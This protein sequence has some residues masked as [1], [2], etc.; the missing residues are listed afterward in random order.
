MKTPFHP[1]DDESRAALLEQA[2]AWLARRDRGLTAA[3]QDAFLHWLHEDPRHREALA[4]LQKAWLTLDGLVEWQPAYSAQPNPDLLAPPRR[5]RRLFW[6]STVLAAGL[7]AAATVALLLRTA[8]PSAAPAPVPAESVA[9]VRIIPGPEREV[10][11]DGSVATL[12]DG[13]R[14]VA[15]FTPSERRVR[16]ISGELYVAVAKNPDRPFV[17]EADGIAVRAIGTAFNVRR[18]SGVLEVLVTEGRVQ[19]ETPAAGPGSAS[20]EVASGQRARLEIGMPARPPAIVALSPAEIAR[21]LDWHS[22]RLEFDELPL[23]AVAHEFNLRN[24]QQLRVADPGTGR[25]RIS[26]TFRSEQVDGFVRL[27]EASYALK[28]TR[29]TDGAWV[30]RRVSE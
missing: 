5:R 20:A 19:I 8:A 14:Y 24:V 21:E 17:V 4:S 7:G 11:P 12:K 27:L 6:V 10:L 16:L 2:S 22:V 26:G 28:A 15:E 23:A 9:G 13:G 3:E 29:D 18:M 25:L 1:H 30:L